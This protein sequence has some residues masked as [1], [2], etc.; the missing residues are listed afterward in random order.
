M[1]DNHTMKKNISGWLL[2]ICLSITILCPL[3]IINSLIVLWGYD[4]FY[5]RLDKS[6]LFTCIYLI[7][8]LLSVLI[9]IYSIYAGSMLWRLRPLAKIIVRKYLVWFLVYHVF[10]TI[11]PYV[12]WVQLMPGLPCN[13]NIRLII[14]G[15]QD[16]IIGSIYFIICYCYITRSERLKSIYG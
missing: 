4:F 15:V 1:N 2:L 12:G 9:S 3:T 6:L 7:Y 10:V 16:L 8:S 13:L 11:L 14:D 5:L